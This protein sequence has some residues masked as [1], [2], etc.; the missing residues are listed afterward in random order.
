MP[1]N[2]ANWRPSWAVIA[3]GAVAVVIAVMVGRYSLTFESGDMH[4]RLAPA[5]PG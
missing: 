5:A 3:V 2:L 1:V 4:I